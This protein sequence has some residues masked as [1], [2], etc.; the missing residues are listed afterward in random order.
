MLKLESFVG[1]FGQILKY[2]LG[3]PGQ[4]QIPTANHAPMYMPH[5]PGG[6]TSS[7]Q[8]QPQIYQ[9]NLN[10][11]AIPT[12]H[13]SNKHHLN[14]RLYNQSL[15]AFHDNNMFTFYLNKGAMQPG[16]SFPATTGTAPIYPHGF[17]SPNQ[18]PVAGNP[19]P[20]H[21]NGPPADQQHSIMTSGPGKP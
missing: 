19:I 16:Q 13:V 17:S 10:H 12:M 18:Q 5:M 14:S 7:P 15:S 6:V 9:Q 8:H 3:I 20:A 11:P 21:V 4:F 1:K 2:S